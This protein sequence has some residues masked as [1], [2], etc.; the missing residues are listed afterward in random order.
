MVESI[1]RDLPCRVLDLGPRKN[2]FE[3]HAEP[4]CMAHGPVAKLAAGHARIENGTAEE[5]ESSM[6]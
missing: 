4:T 6:R 2:V 1:E 5:V 3:A